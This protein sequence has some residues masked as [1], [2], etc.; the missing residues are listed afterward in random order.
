MP[1]VL[2]RHRV[3]MGERWRE[4]SGAPGGRRN[5]ALGAAS[6]LEHEPAVPGTRQRQADLEAVAVA[7][8]VTAHP[9]VDDAINLTMRGE[10]SRRRGRWVEL[11][12]DLGIR[13][14]EIGEI[15]QILARYRFTLRRPRRNNRSP[16]RAE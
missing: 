2:A 8:T 15:S 4:R 12:R 13:N 14:R 5:G 9:C 6:T 3:T 16:N 1:S 7:A 10:R 11:G